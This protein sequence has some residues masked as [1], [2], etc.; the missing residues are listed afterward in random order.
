MAE[1]T[2]TN[3]EALELM[4][5]QQTC[6]ECQECCKWLTVVWDRGQFTPDL[7]HFYAIRGCRFTE[8]GR[9]IH[10]CIPTICSHLRFERGCLIYEERPDVCKK[11]DGREDVTM[12]GICKLV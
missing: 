10:V 11:Y 6:I 5:E 12:K 7:R 1:E 9:W 2:P 4:N 3:K 8:Q